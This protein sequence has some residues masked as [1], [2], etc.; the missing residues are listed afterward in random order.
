MVIVKVVFGQ[1]P[2]SLMEEVE[3]AVAN[4]EED[5]PDGNKFLIAAQELM[6]YSDHE[7]LCI[8]EKQFNTEAEADAYLEGVSDGEGWMGWSGQLEGEE[9]TNLEAVLAE[10][11]KLMEKKK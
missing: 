7:S 5:H 1:L 10:R 11:D 4:A 8:T 9:L 2:T 6:T 3:C